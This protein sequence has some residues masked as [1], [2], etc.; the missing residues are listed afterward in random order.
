MRI[1]STTARMSALVALATLVAACAGR[2]AP[3]THGPAVAATILGAGSV[4]TE[5]T[6]E[7]VKAPDTAEGSV[8]EVEAYWTPEFLSP[9]DKVRAR[10]GTSIG[11]Q[12]RI[13]GPEFLDIVPLRTRVT[14]PPIKDP[15]PAREPASTSGTVR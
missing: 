7:R 5:H 15:T 3:Q 6:G 11:I 2:Q 4:I 10:L 9:P 12:V 13:D 14:H 8:G 1:R